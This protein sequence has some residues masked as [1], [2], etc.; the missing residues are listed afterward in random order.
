ME[1]KV[2]DKVLELDVVGKTSEQIKGME[3]KEFCRT[4][5]HLMRVQDATDGVENS[6][7]AYIHSRALECI[8][9][10]GGF[11]M[12]P[13]NREAV[14]RDFIGTLN[15]YEVY[16]TSE[17]A[18]KCRVQEMPKPIDAAKRKILGGME[19]CADLRTEDT[20]SKVAKANSKAKK[21]KK[22]ADEAQLLADYQAAQPDAQGNT[23]G[24]PTDEID[25]QLSKIAEQY[26]ELRGINPERAAEMLDGV[27]KRI[28]ATLTELRGKVGERLTA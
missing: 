20:C 21:D 24:D 23:S 9:R 6:I 12:V 15:K 5:V 16:L 19:R 18:G 8:D 26:K 27:Q 17:E 25:V 14:K 4:A 13:E 2:G 11:P 22:L 3:Y 10:N 28:T 7:A 1:L